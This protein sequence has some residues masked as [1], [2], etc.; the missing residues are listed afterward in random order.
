M[1]GALVGNGFSVFR[2]VSC[3]SRAIY[4]T[5]VDQS[6]EYRRFFWLGAVLE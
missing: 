2:T 1:E 5:L 3:K 6:P 4:M